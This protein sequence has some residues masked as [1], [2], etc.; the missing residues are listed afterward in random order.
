MALVVWWSSTVGFFVLRLVFWLGVLLNAGAGSLFWLVVEGAS[1][2]YAFV[3]M[4]RD[5]GEKGYGWSLFVPFW[6]AVG[7]LCMV[8]FRVVPVLP[9]VVLGMVASCVVVW[10]LVSLGTRYTVGGVR[11]VSV[12][13]RGPYAFV[14]HPQQGARLLVVAGAYLG[15]LPGVVAVL[16]AVASV[17]VV[18]CEESF[19]RR[20]AAY[21]EYA[22]RVPWRLLP[23][24]A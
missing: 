23:G 3:G 11:L 6:Y 17:M 21:R 24:F 1:L 20:D 9:G 16:A 2:A 5:E 18:V 12:V 4:W 13:D 15:G 14:R 8:P 7:A 22:A 19:L 10:A